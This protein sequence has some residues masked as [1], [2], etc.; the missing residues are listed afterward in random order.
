MIRLL[1]KIFKLFAFLYWLLMSGLF[2]LIYF[3]Q[4][5]IDSLNVIEK[6]EG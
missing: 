6:E 5:K 1:K 3:R 2:L 4:K